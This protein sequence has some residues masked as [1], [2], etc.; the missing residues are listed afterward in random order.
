VLEGTPDLPPDVYNG[1]ILTVAKNLWGEADLRT[2]SVFSAATRRQEAT[3][4]GEMRFA[5]AVR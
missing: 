3:K 2:Q 1:M 5:A 4:R